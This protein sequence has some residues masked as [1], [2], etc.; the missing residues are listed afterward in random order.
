MKKFIDLVWVLIAKPFLYLFI[1]T[2]LVMLTDYTLLAY[3]IDN[4]NIANHAMDA[5][6]IA[7]LFKMGWDLHTWAETDYTSQ[8]N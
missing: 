1:G 5:L 7:V 4:R 3:S 8:I 6:T 2:A